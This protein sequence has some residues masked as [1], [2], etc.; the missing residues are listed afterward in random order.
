MIRKIDTLLSEYGESHRNPVNRRI[1]WVS[2][3][4]IVWGLMTLLWSLPVPGMFSAVPGLNWLTICLA[5]A[6]VY[7][8][9][10]SPTLAV[11]FFFLALVGVGLIRGYEA[12]VTFPL[13]QFGLLLFVLGWIG[14]FLGHSI[15][16]NSPS[17]F[18]DLR[19]LLIGP[20]WLLHFV[21][22]WMNVPY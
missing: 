6:L 7:Y 8:L 19:F 14:Q 17:F 11:G 20:A 10:L 9:V 12:V 5:P 2:V 15:E 4:I 13:W 3:P 18:K 1:H 21:Y 16:G 22:R